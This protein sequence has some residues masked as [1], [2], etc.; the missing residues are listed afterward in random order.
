MTAAEPIESPPRTSP[1]PS[2]WFG[3][4]FVAAALY[5]STA[6]RGPQWQDPGWHQW[7]IVTGQI[8]HPLGLALVHP[9]H[10]WLARAAMFALPLEPVFAITLVSSVAGAA[11]VANLGLLVW[12]LTRQTAAALI[13]AAAFM[14]SHTFWQHATVTE[15]YTLVAL[16]LTSE[17]L[18]LAAF[19]RGGGAGWLLAAA[20]ASGVGVANHLLAGLTLPVNLVLL[21]WLVRR[22]RVSAMMIAACAVAWMIGTLPYSGLVA[23]RIADSG[24]V[25]GTVHS[26]LFGHF[27]DS[28]LNTRVNPRMLA[29]SLGFI[30]YNFPGLTIPLAVYCVARRTLQP[31]AMCWILVAE[32]AIYLAFSLRYPIVDQYT[33]FFTAYA[34]MV[35]LAGGGLASLMTRAS[36]AWRRTL[37][38]TAAITA[39]WTPAVYVAA[40]ATFSSLGWFAGMV[41]N[42]PCRDGYRAFLL[43]WGD[44]GHGERLC[45]QTF[46]AGGEDAVILVA[47]N[48]VEYA[49]R[50]HQ[51]V[52][53]ASP[54]IEIRR[55][56]SATNPQAVDLDA[57]RAR[58]LLAAGRQVILVPRDRDR[59]EVSLPGF[60]FERHGDV[61]EVISAVPTETQPAN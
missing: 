43:P 53:R 3:L 9:V 4:F 60:V 5:V 50:Y 18:C 47:D 29:L 6:D 45:R 2:I 54:D 41:G 61:Y 51:H 33:Y 49:L 44:S 35:V 55:M 12:L 25:A 48:M 39:L 21:V 42:K 32:F 26:A 57:A 17:W 34:A 1:G 31:A 11:A 13:S 22:R 56:E 36:V 19:L 38:T 15:S 14:L 40:C 24:D 46:A 23:L 30:L 28:V 20:G 52:R 59:P 58:Q 37:A 27:Q 8:D 16:L 10:Y 7:R